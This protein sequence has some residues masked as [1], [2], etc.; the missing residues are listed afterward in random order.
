MQTHK[1]FISEKNSK[2]EKIYGEK[3]QTVKWQQRK[4]RSE[5][6]NRKI[7]FC[8]CRDNCLP[9]D[10]NRDKFIEREIFISTLVEKI[11]SFGRR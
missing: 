6:M 4:R 1:Y 11:G 7:Y 9:F 3:Q 8:D 2:P 5:T 10:Y